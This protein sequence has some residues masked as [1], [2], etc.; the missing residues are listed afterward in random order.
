MAVQSTLSGVVNTS[1]VLPGNIFDRF[2]HSFTKHTYTLYLFT[3]SDIRTTLIPITC[4]ALAAAPDLQLGHILHSVCW[5]WIH[6]LQFDVSNQTLSEEEDKQNKSDR[7]LPAGRM[8]L[9]NALIFRWI[10]VPVCWLYSLCY[11]VE[12]FYASV[13]LVALTYIYDEMGAHSGHWIVRNVVNACGFASFEMGATL[14]ATR[15]RTYLDGVA[16]L[17]ICCSAGIFATTIH[18]QDFKDVVGDAAVGRRTL[19]ITQPEFARFTVPVV[20]TLWSIGLGFTWELGWYT[21]FTFLALAIVTSWRF[22]FLRS[23]RQDQITFYY[24]YNIWLSAAHALPGYYR[25]F[26]A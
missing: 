6:L 18:T 20:L 19:P 22:F 2:F 26:R 3:K 13:A 17:A 4:F 14:V 7:P 12:T 25:H 23:I 24:W 5:I 15:D 8:T 1:G 11:S 21:S 10:L 9:R 16:I